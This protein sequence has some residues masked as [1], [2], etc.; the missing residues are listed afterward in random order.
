MKIHE[1]LK[2][3]EKQLEVI[4]SGSARLDALVL[5]EYC[6]GINRAQILAE[7]YTELSTAQL[8]KLEKLLKRR[9][10][11]EPIS[12]ILER[13]EFYGRDFVIT[14]AVLEPRPESETMIDMFMAIAKDLHLDQ[15]D[16]SSRRLLRIAD[17]GSGSGALGITAA[18]EAPNTSVDLLDIDSTTLKIAKINVDKFTLS[19]NIIKS[20][21]LDH[22]AMDYDILLCNLPYVPDDYHINQAATHEP[23]IAIFGGSDGLSL[24]RKLFLQ[25]SKLPKQPLYILTEALPFQHTE[26]QDIARHQGYQLEKTDDFIQL[27]S[28]P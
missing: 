19:I 26:L 9:T 18:L 28:K 10:L 16:F 27:F 1:W 17:V 12:Y 4:G 7:P 8:A 5:M 3:A 20:D 11:H 15:K 21:L 2:Q 13:T 22:S 25:V 24:Y 14:S 6:L 23:R